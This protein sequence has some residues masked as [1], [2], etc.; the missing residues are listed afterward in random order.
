MT[1]AYRARVGLKRGV[2]DQT[3]PGLLNLVL[4]PW[5]LGTKHIRPVIACCGHS[6]V[7]EGSI[8]SDPVGT[9]RATTTRLA[10]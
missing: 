7:D 10:T 8:A 4:C 9:N 1:R 3:D 2:C 5:V 6:G